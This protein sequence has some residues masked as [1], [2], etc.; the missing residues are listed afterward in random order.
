ME[1]TGS[2]AAAPITTLEELKVATKTVRTGT[3]SQVDALYSRVLSTMSWYYTQFNA[4]DKHEYATKRNW[5]EAMLQLSGKG[6]SDPHMFA[7]MLLKMTRRL[8][9]NPRT[10]HRGRNLL[11]ELAGNSGHLSMNLLDLYKDLAKRFKL[12]L[13]VGPGVSQYEGDATV[14]P[15]TFVLSAN[16]DGGLTIR[17]MQAGGARRDPAPL[18]DGTWGG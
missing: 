15:L 1:V 13:T 3:D 9:A 2:A 8:L 5:K 6:I 18:L 4:S 16:N 11:V 12:K 17:L 7:N 10:E 14:R